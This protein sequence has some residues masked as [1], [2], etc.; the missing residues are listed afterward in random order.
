MSSSLND[1][2]DPLATFG[3][4]F[5]VDRLPQAANRC[6]RTIC[7]LQGD[8]GQRWWH[9]DARTGG[10]VEGHPVYS[11]HH[12]AM[13]SMVLFDLVEAGGHDYWKEITAGLLWMERVAPIG[14]SRWPST[15][16]AARTIS[17]GCSVHG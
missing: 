4:R 8:Q 7:E 1:H 6:A 11:V 17:A 15:V 14:R 12:D 13:R 16:I 5:Q 9:S 3:A 10:V 2:C